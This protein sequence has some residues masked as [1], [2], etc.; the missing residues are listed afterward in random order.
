MSE[1]V[2]GK[3]LGSTNQV[4]HP[5][6]RPLGRSLPWARS[7]VS[8][9][10]YQ[11][12]KSPD[13]R[14]HLEFHPHFLGREVT[15]DRGVGRSRGVAMRLDDRLDPLEFFPAGDIAPDPQHVSSDVP[16]SAKAAEIV[17]KA[18]VACSST[19]GGKPP[20]STS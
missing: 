8:K 1:F 14:G 11:P 13:T 18:S 7:R 4:T 6:E 10:P 19:V 12:P 5:E 3:P 9:D 2:I 20:A 15:V 16:A 17:A